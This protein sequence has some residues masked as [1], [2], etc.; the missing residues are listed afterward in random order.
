[1]KN[2]LLKYSILFSTIFCLVGCNV[3]DNSNPSSMENTMIHTVTFNP[4]NGESNIVVEVKH[5][6]KVSKPFTPSY[7]GHTFGGW[8][9][10]N[11]EQW[12]FSG[13]LVTED[14]TLTAKWTKVNEEDSSGGNEDSSNGNEDSSGGENIDIGE[15]YSDAI[16]V[17]E[18]L[19]IAKGLESGAESSQSYYVKGTIDDIYNTQYGNCH[20]VDGTNDIL[21]YGMYN[22][23]GTVR[24]DEMTRKPLEGEEVVVY[25]TIMNY[26]DSKNKVNKY[27]IVDAWLMAI[28]GIS[29]DPNYSASEDDKNENDD[30][31]NNDGIT[32]STVKNLSFSSS[33]L[34]NKNKADLDYY[35][36]GCPSI[37]SPN[38]LVVPVEFSDVTASS[39][40]Y[41]TTAIKN[42]FLPKSQTNAELDYYS[43]YDYFYTSSYGKLSLNIEV[44]DN[45]FKP[46]NNSTYYKNA[47][48]E[49]DG[50]KF[51]GGDQ[52]ILDEILQYL[53]N[54]GVDLS[55]YDSDNDTVIDSVVMVSTLPIDD[56]ENASMLHWA[57]QY[58]NYY[59]DNEGYYYEYDGVSANAYLWAPYQFMY[60]T[61]T[62]YDSKAPTNTYTFIHEFSHVLGADDY[63]DT[64]Y[65]NHPLEGYDIMDAMTAD[66]NPFTK[67]HYGWIESSRLVTASDKVTL[68]LTAFEETGDT[69]IVANNYNEKKG[70]YQEYWLIVYYTD[71]KLNEYPYG[72]FDEGVVVYH[73]NAEV[74]SSSGYEYFINSNTDA[75]DEYYGSV[76]NLIEFVKD[77]NDFI[78]T[79]GEQLSST[80]KDDNN[81]KVPYTFKI[82][83][84]NSEK[85][86]LTFTKN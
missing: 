10:E 36:Y 76:N 53:D 65:T 9:D 2:S 39:K 51:E 58:Y 82:D 83:S 67:M 81:V 25:G 27:E 3:N 14:I 33:S 35:E 50:E 23:D 79:V 4:N 45:W 18:A 44:L 21:I 86:T 28:N 63:Y 24:Y 60:E 34:T 46:K 62:G 68:E 55:K 57:F 7:E 61:E 15:A 84:I 17:Y 41:T 40:G 22:Y 69:I 59:V 73:I 56:D 70:I 49:Y 31:Q 43:V 29:L 37:G 32:T 1:M 54:Q 12:N 5:N 13:Y 19:Q 11:G 26:Y 30:N 74:D 66:H 78:Y 38:V 48:I 80:I 47:T 6:D 71:T 85:V 52:L 77:G 72:L 75:S 8:F 64:T 20:L 42:A 16:S